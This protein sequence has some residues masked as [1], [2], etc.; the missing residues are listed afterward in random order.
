MHRPLVLEAIKIYHNIVHKASGKYEEVPD[1]MHVTDILHLIEDYA[2]GVKDS[3]EYE[4][5]YSAR[6]YRVVIR[7]ERDNDCPTRNEIKNKAYFFEAFNVDYV[8]DYSENTARRNY[9]EHGEA[10]KSAH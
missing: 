5:A 9:T 7:T 4:E 2:Y 8:E 10:N 3:A 1:D 6:T